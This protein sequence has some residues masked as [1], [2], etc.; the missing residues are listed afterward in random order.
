MPPVPGTVLGPAVPIRQL[1]RPKTEDPPAEPVAPLPK[2]PAPTAP[3][4]AEPAAEPAADN[5]PCYHVPCRRGLF[6]RR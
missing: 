6:P 1:A 4:A 3:P 2:P 5:S